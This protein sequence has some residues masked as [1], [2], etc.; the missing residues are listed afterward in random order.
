[1]SMPKNKR[2]K[3]TIDNVVYYYHVATLPVSDELI[4]YVTD[5]E[6]KSI[7]ET[8]IPDSEVLISRD[9]QVHTHAV[10]VTPANIEAYIRRIL[11][12]LP[13][14]D[15]RDVNESY[16]YSREQVDA[17]RHDLLEQIFNAANSTSNKDKA[18]KKMSE[19][20]RESLLRGNF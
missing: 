8:K 19:I 14:R 9:L 20:M 13:S 5:E 4:I 11:Q 17:F 7:S 10:K 16:E 6:G 15:Y 1:M 12:L 3:I 18:F 2:R